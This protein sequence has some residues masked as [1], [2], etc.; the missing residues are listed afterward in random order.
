MEHLVEKLE[1]ALLSIDRL[2][3]RR[4]MEEAHAGMQPMA[5][6]EKLLVPVLERI[7]QG[8]EEG[9]LALSQVYMSG[10]ISEELVDTLLPPGHAHRKKQPRLAIAVLD[11]YHMLGKRLVYSVLRADGFDLLDYGAVNVE[12]LISRTKADNIQVLLISTLMLPSALRVKEVTGGLK[13]KGLDTKVVVGGAPFRFD[14][15]L[16]QEVEADAMGRNAS[17]AVAVINNLGG[18]VS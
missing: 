14:E 9:R 3:A 10:R 17:D 13:K 12:T 16:W 8:W 15:Q 5:I 11:D 4:V 7:G 1:Q 6:A 18:G 2:S